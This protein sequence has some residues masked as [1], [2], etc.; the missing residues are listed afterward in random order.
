M[1]E[2]DATPGA[3]RLDS[4]TVREF[5]SEPADKQLLADLE[6]LTNLIMRGSLNPE[7]VF[8]RALVYEALGYSDLAAADAYLALALAE[9]AVDP[10]F[11]S[12]VPRYSQAVR[13]PHPEAPEKPLELKL[14]SLH[15]LITCLIDLGCLQDALEFY[16]RLD[17]VYKFL[18]SP[19]DNHHR[20]Y[21]W[22]MD[23]NRNLSDRKNGLV[24]MEDLFS[25]DS[26]LSTSGF[27]RR[28]I[29]PW[30]SYEPDRSSDDTLGELNSRLK[31]AAPGLEARSTAL[32]VLHDLP[33]RSSAGAACKSILSNSSIQHNE[34]VSIQLGLFATENLA[35]G[36]SIL[37]EKSLLTAI[38]SLHTS[39]CD[40]CA[41]PLPGLSPSNPPVQCLHCTDTVFCSQACHDLAQAIYHPI[42][43]DNEEE[44]ESLGRDPESRTPSDDLHFLLIVRALAM[45]EK[46][47]IH[48]LELS[49][50]KYL[51][52]GFSSPSST[53]SP[54]KSTSFHSAQTTP[55]KSL[56]FSFHHNV[57]LPFRIFEYLWVA[58][59]NA[60]QYE[61]SKYD[62]W[63]TQTLYAK[64]R[65][66]ASARQSTW[67]GKPEVA[68]IHPLWSLANH[69]CAPNVEWEWG[70][71]VVY[72]VRERPVWS[73]GSTDGKGQIEEETGWRGIKRDEEILNH[74]CDI[75]LPVEERKAW[76]WGALS[77][78]CMCQRCK[79]ESRERAQT[80]NGR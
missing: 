56:P 22:M 79:W 72:K 18:D 12:L 49:E 5:R 15:L 40:A 32:P 65:G 52:G 29:Y 54:P 27:S 47:G 41:S 51:W 57:I 61:L 25:R 73:K 24:G 77:G 38:R 46:Q 76:A 14:L 66:V 10:A 70:G 33:K 69:S 50:V 75:D 62:F 34:A 68:V 6:R 7:D 20:L 35:P 26:K 74:Y 67:D 16:G 23:R 17:E 28:E 37:R 9:T 80:T 45:A 78:E 71:E 64:F 2:D 58:R 31:N 11:S 59:Q 39:L 19:D 30:N 43:C 60:N 8:S 53:R 44:L 3:P 13:W 4:S 21:K 63:I 1:W 36:T 48:P 55:L 42:F